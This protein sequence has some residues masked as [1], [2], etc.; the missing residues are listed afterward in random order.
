TGF[1]NLSRY[2]QNK[3]VYYDKNGQMLYGQQAIDGH[4]YLFNKYNG[5][6]LTGFQNLADYGQDKV[7]YYD[8]N[9]QMLHGRQTIDKQS[10]LFDTISGAL[11]KK[12]DE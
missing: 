7:V 3:T 9:G 1:Q 5:A 8:K 2:G 12:I 11:I 10:Y 6:M 4:W